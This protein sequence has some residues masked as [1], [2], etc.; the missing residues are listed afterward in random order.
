LAEELHSL[1][2]LYRWGVDEKRRQLGELLRHLADLENQ[3]VRLGEELLNEQHAAGASPGEA[4]YL[5]G[6]YAEAVIM[7]REKIAEASAETE[8]R[9]A[10]AREELNEAYRELKKYEIAQENR[11]KAEARELSLKEQADLDELGIKGFIRKRQ[12][13]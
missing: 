7:R 12:R 10:A 13:A 8:E 9:I 6:Y 11:E 1:I 3:G 5:Y 4:G 2:R